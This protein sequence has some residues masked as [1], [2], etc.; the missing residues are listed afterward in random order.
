MAIPC[1][2][3][4]SQNFRIVLRLPILSSLH[5]VT[6]DSVSQIPL[7]CSLDSTVNVT[8][9]VQAS[10]TV[11]SAFHDS[12]SLC[13]LLLVSSS[14][15]H[16]ILFLELFQWHSLVY[17]IKSKL[18]WVEDGCQVLL[19]LRPPPIQTPYL[20]LSSSSADTLRYYTCVTNLTVAL[21]LCTCYSTQRTI[22]S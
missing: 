10:P 2:A 5:P 13:S 15:S 1:N 4:P 9:V 8:S 16:L 3:S 7:I 11:Y 14:K 6:L 17:N 20:L 18:A 12:F 22:T 19:Y 21:N